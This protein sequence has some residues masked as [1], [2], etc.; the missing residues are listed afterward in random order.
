MPAKLYLLFPLTKCLTDLM[1]RVT[2][3][4]A[5]APTVLI[6]FFSVKTQHLL[7]DYVKRAL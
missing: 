5:P 6:M 1:Y 7:S 2:D 4:S 3:M